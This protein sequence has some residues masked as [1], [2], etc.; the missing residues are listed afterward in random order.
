MAQNLFMKKIILTNDS[1]KNYNQKD[2]LKILLEDNVFNLNQKELLKSINEIFL[3][4]I[5]DNNIDPR[6][7]IFD[8]KDKADLVA[9]IQ[10]SV[11]IRLY[12]KDITN[13][14][15]I[16][17]FIISEYSELEII[18]KFEYGTI[19]LT[20]N[21]FVVKTF[22]DIQ[23]IID[24]EELSQIS[25]EDFDNQFK[26]F[27]SMQVPEDYENHHSTENILAMKEWKKAL[28]IKNNDEKD[29]DLYFRY[30]LSKNLNYN[31]EEI[32]KTFLKNYNA[33]ILIVEDQ[34]KEG[35]RDIF[36]EIFGEKN[37]KIRFLGDDFSGKSKEEICKLVEKEVDEF[38]PNFV[39]TDLR[40]HTDDFSSNI[41]EMTG[42]RI[43][44]NIKSKNFGIH[45]FC[46]SV[47]SKAINLKK[48]N[49]IEL[50]EFIPKRFSDTIHPIKELIEKFKEYEEIKYISEWV[51]KIN[52]QRK[53]L[54]I[55]KSSK[56]NTTVTKDFSDLGKNN[57]ENIIR[58]K[59]PEIEAFQTYLYIGTK[60]LSKARIFKNQ[61]NLN[62]QINNSNR[63]YIESSFLNYFIA[64]EYIYNFLFEVSI[65]E[66]K[67]DKKKYFINKKTAKYLYQYE[68][69]KNK[70][71]YISTGYYEAKDKKNIDWSNK[72]INTFFEIS[73]SGEIKDINSLIKKRNDLI[74][75][76]KSNINIKDIT[77]LFDLISD[78]DITPNPTN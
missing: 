69:D 32:D 37:E 11:Y 58:L 71:E 62:D 53:K 7:V 77:K 16:P 63:I 52:V 57:D 70:N 76:N 33:K 2:C 43:I 13:D 14:E 6:S 41:E 3:D 50:N 56:K 26:H 36:F 27:F 60:L 20:P 40:L 66:D 21:V 10:Y 78:L 18:K 29:Y 45:I 59:T 23:N 61:K 12:K 49:T 22:E 35:W 67:N 34:L 5:D 72:V 68:F 30:I 51:D 44:E 15:P 24:R 48:L 46:M 64:F 47:T 1:N 9:A 75:G 55:F 38:K 25:R 73:P 74:H 4:F 19:V 31:V 8:F 28:N 42:Y 54:E 39:I 65:K 17:I